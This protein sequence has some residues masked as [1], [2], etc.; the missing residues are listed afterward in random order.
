[1]SESY[2][3]MAPDT[4]RFSSAELHAQLRLAFL[5]RPPIIFASAPSSKILSAYI[6]PDCK[7]TPLLSGAIITLPPAAAA[8][9]R[10]SSSPSEVLSS[11]ALPSSGGTTASFK[12]PVLVVLP[13]TGGGDHDTKALEAKVREL[14][15]PKASL[16]RVDSNDPHSAEALRDV[17]RWMIAQGF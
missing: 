2:T 16:L 10:T 3:R 1:M 17:E 5:Q 15:G 8:N 4:S 12:A 7:S 6:S 13:G 11:S 14:W 9:F